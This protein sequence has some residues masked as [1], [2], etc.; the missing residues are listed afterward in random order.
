MSERDTQRVII[1][2]LNINHNAVWLN[3]IPIGL[4]SSRSSTGRRRPANR[5]TADIVGCMKCTGRMI[6]IE[7]KDPKYKPQISML[8]K[9]LL[10]GD[11][12]KYAI[13]RCGNQEMTERVK[14]QAEFLLW[15]RKTGAIAGFAYCLEDVQRLIEESK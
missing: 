13:F 8:W 2:W 15:Q 12:S 5:G 9:A 14:Q 4:P 6:C 10:H 11:Y 7:V 1:D 3:E